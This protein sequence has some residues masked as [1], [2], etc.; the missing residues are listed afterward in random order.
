MIASKHILPIIITLSVL[1]V[2][3]KDTFMGSILKAKE[4]SSKTI[5]IESELKQIDIHGVFKVVLVQD[6]TNKAV[7]WGNENS[8]K[9]VE[10][11]YTDTSLVITNSPSSGIIQYGQGTTSVT[12][13]YI[14]FTSIKSL[15]IHDFVE[16]LSEGEIK[17]DFFR[18]AFYSVAAKMNI[19]IDTQTFVFFSLRSTGEFFVSGK[20]DYVRIVAARYEHVYANYLQ[21]KT[22]LVFNHSFGDIYLNASDKVTLSIFNSGNIYYTGS[23]SIIVEEKT[24]TGNI[25]PALS[26]N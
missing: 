7:I 22:A 4:D 21:A 10:L 18:V 14:H 11:T 16:L 26:N 15:Y 19:K 24:G 17:G 9:K 20:T 25:L 1:F 2:S 5:P 12:T 13:V 3:C 23:P 6:S 8:I